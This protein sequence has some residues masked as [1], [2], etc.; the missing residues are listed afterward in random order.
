M[1]LKF[2]YNPKEKQFSPGQK[3]NFKVL[4]SG[5]KLTNKTDLTFGISTVFSNLDNKFQGVA[6]S[7]NS[8]GLTI[9]NTAKIS[10]QK[11]AADYKYT[12]N[13]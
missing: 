9:T 1:P 5:T 6:Q 2:T 12:I 3:V 8:I 10:T 4:I 7:S 13:L 11:V